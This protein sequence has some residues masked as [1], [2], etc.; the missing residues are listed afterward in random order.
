[1]IRFILKRLIPGYTRTGD[2]DVRLRYLYVHHVSLIGFGIML[3]VIRFVTGI[4][5]NSA[6]LVADGVH[7]WA[8]VV[9]P[10]VQFFSPHTRLV[11]AHETF[12]TERVRRVVLFS[13]AFVLIITGVE[14]GKASLERIL[15]P[16]PVAANIV[17]IAVIAAV[18]CVNLWL[19]FFAAS[20]GSVLGTQSART[21]TLNARRDTV[22]TAIVLVGFLLRLFG[23]QSIIDGVMGLILSGVIIYNGFDIAKESI[24]SMRGESPDGAFL[25]A[26]R[27]AAQGVPGI[28]GIHSIAVHTYGKKSI[29]S[30]DADIDDS[31][32]FT[33][34]TSTCDA[35]ESLLEKKLSVRAIIR[36]RPVSTA[37]GDVAHLREDVERVTRHMSEVSAVTRVRIEGDA[38]S[39]VFHCALTLDRSTI[40]ERADEI[41][42]RIEREM[43]G[44]HPKL[45]VVIETADRR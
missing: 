43:L 20:L 40:P 31:M 13:I 45:R 19:S 27:S 18:V 14:F 2:A 17:A 11:G 15:T 4:V 22:I 10:S 21:A 3:G 41:R 25:D 39:G 42:T 1:M 38:E 33:A 32:S 34:A 37:A 9:P 30:F 44:K 26:I 8:S 16:Q 35:A 24:F 7:A 28:L 23:V 5:A 29:V 36:P 6:A 12:K